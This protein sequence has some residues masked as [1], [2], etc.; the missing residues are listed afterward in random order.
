VR[1]FLPDGEL[2]PFVNVS[3]TTP[4]VYERNELYLVNDLNTQSLKTVQKSIRS[5]QAGRLTIF[6]D[7]SAHEIGINR[8]GDRPNISI[9]SVEIT[10]MSWATHGKDVAL[11]VKLLNKG[12]SGGKNITAK[13]SSTKNNVNIKQN[14]VGFGAIDV[15]AIRAGQTQFA[16]QIAT[17]DI[18]II[19]FR[20]DIRD[21]NKNQWVEFFDM[22][23]KK[24]VPHIND[25]EIADGR[26]FTVA[27]AG[28]DTETLLLGTGNG[29]GKAN[30]GESI[31]ILVKD[32]GKYWR[33]DLTF[34]DPY[35]NPFGV[36][37]RKS[38]YW[39][40]Y[41]HVGGSAKY[42]IPLIS[43]DCPQNHSL[44]FFAEYWLP[45]YPLHT[46]K[47]GVV[48]IEVTGKDK[49]PPQISW[50]QVAGDNVLKAKVYDGSK[51]QSVK[52]RLILKDD[53]TQWLDLE[54]K[55]D[56]KSGDRVEADNV[57]SKKIPDR[58]FGIY[59][60]VVEATDSFGNK[61]IGENQNIFVIH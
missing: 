33:T 29:D 61:T 30:P 12:I 51:I 32:Q 1:E 45:D 44:S 46:I 55:D 50:V 59:R 5:D 40:N 8:E 13:L 4:A 6:L 11:S 31:A 28:N 2:L 14:V 35:L 37:I 10:N 39:G 53:P 42:D 38:D 16:F 15:N 20:L 48:A 24:D 47:Q 41:D 49:T 43:S 34:S 27:K 22:P 3:V 19:K 54:L 57:F 25:V 21:E 7:G 23:L 56:G 26:I 36:N 9:A 58:R 60:A 18:E 52:A 17:A